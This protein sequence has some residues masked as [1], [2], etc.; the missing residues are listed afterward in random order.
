[1][2]VN[3]LDLIPENVLNVMNMYPYTLSEKI[4]E[5]YHDTEYYFNYTFD[6][7]TLKLMTILPFDL[8]YMAYSLHSGDY[9]ENSGLVNINT[10]LELF[11]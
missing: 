8:K 10:L 11:E 9:H 3:I 2:S 4:N 7:G 6:K 1:M 5:K